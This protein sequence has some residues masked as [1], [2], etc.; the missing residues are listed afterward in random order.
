M[1]HTAVITGVGPGLGASLARK[2]VQEGCRVGMFARS[3]D[4]VNSLAGELNRGRDVALP[5]PADITVPDQLVRGFRSVR[6]R[7]GPVDIVIHHAGNAV[8]GGVMDITAEQ[9]D[10]AWRVGPYAGFLCAREALP[11]MLSRGSGAI[12]FTGATS[13]VRGRG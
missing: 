4:Y 3:P 7:Y 5:V 11:D 8:W 10:Q 6:D 12:L 2:L 13:S 9:F 1:T